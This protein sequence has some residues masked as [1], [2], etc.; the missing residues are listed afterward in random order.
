M[1]N[2]GI[3]AAI[4]ELHLK[5]SE[6][7]QEIVD[8]KKAINLLRSTIGEPPEFADLQ[9]ETFKRSAQI[10][11]DQF[12]RKSITAAAREYLK[13]KGSAATV[14]EIIEALKR[15][16]CDLGS[17]PLRNVK[18]SLSKNSRTFAT[19]SDDVFG[20]WDFYGGS[21]RLKKDS[22]EDS[23]TEDVQPDEIEHAE[24]SENR[25]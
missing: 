14:A 5:L 23:V 21:P 1:A 11:P 12:F 15:G 10:R 17:S 8:T 4:E 25:S 3:R 18:I 20:L 7:Q 22:G 16:G 13:A 2:D 24:E 9:E 19:I 6:K